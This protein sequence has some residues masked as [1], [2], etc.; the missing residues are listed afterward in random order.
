MKINKFIIPENTMVIID[1]N[2]SIDG[3]IFETLTI[4]STSI[5]YINVFNYTFKTYGIT[6]EGVLKLGRNSTFRKLFS[7]TPRDTYLLYPG[8]KTYYIGK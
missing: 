8:F 3:N 6:I 1:S 5:L 2:E 4:P 7:N